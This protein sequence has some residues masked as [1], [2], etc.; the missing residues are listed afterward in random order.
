VNAASGAGFDYAAMVISIRVYEDG[1]RVGSFEHFVQICKEQ[2]PAEVIARRVLRSEGLVR[3][4]NANDFN[5]RAVKRMIEKSLDVSV[6]EANDGDT[7][8]N[9][10]LSSGILAWSR[11]SGVQSKSKDKEQHRN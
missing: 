1:L 8:W 6:D 10:I 4:G 2:I 5:L 11:R 9:L 7:K 3:F